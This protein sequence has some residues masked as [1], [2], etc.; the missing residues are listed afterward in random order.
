MSNNT[1]SVAIGY[2]LWVF[3]FTGAH[4]FYFG[5]RKTGL[6]WL[7]TGG[8]FG[9]GWLVDVLLIPGMDRS[10]DHRYAAG[11]ANYNLA[12]VLLTFGGI[13]GL[14]HFYL[15]RFLTGLLWLVTGGLLGVGWAYDFWRMNEMVHEANLES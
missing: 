13:L 6:L 11:R 4:R 9:I 12:W 7:L 2:L 15:G 10:A 3:G 1:H 8:L 14:H 5:K